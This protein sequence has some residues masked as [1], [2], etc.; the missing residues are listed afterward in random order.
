VEKSVAL[1]RV[2]LQ[3]EGDERNSGSVSGSNERPGGMK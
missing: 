1:E 3:E 2:I